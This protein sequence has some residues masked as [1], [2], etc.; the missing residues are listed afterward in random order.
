MDGLLIPWPVFLLTL[1]GATL[2]GF[3]RLALESAR[4]RWGGRTIGSI[5]LSLGVATFAFLFTTTLPRLSHA[6]DS[7]ET[8]PTKKSDTAASVGVSAKDTPAATASKSPNTTAQAELESP[9]T[10]VKVDLEKRPAWVESASH[11]DGEVHTVSVSSGPWA[12]ESECSRALNAKLQ[13]ATDDY[14]REYLHSDLA[15]KKLHY[16][17]SY[18][19]KHLVREQGVYQE[20]LTVS[21]G[22]MKQTHALLQFDS[23]FRHELEH[24]WNQVI[25]ASRLGQ[26]GVVFGGLLALLGTFFG[27]FKLDHATRGFY[28]GRLQFGMAAVI[29]TLVAAGIASAVLIKWL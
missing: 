18:I 8:E 26:T 11:Q 5:S 15:P 14:I 21:F 23:A 9:I 10:T 16:D 12:T 22:Q 17:L 13:Q 2:Y 24:R 4:D 3:R 1:I 28:A 27:Y 20:T 29:L 25:A 7:P 19:K 6:F